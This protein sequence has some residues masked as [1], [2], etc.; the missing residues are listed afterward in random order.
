MAISKRLFDFIAALVIGLFLLP[1]MLII[2]TLVKVD[3]TGPVIYWSNR[4]GYQGRLFLM[5]KFRSMNVKTPILATHLLHNSEQY[6]TRVGK[7]IRKFSLDE[8]PQIWSIL[9]G[10]M[11]FVGPRPAL[12]NQEDLINMRAERGLE[13]MLPGLTGWAQIN[14]RDELSTINKVDLDEE[15]LRR[16]SLIFDIQILWLTLFKVL[17]RKNIIH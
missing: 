13:L 16:Q 3:S 9:K 7:I 11:S 12:Y 8:L 1:L 10:D 2:A 15:Y 4:V 5:P 6:L 14:G 17:A